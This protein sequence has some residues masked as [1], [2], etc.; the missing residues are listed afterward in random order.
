[1]NARGS[2]L[3]SCPSHRGCSTGQRSPLPHSEAKASS[4]MRSNSAISLAVTSCQGREPA[5]L[6]NL[7][8]ANPPVN[9][10]PH[11][12]VVAGNGRFHKASSSWCRSGRPAS[13]AAFCWR[14]SGA[15]LLSCSHP[16]TFTTDFEELY[17]P[18]VHPCIRP[19]HPTVGRRSCRA[20]LPNSLVRR[21]SNGSAVDGRRRRN[22]GRT[23]RKASATARGVVAGVSLSAS[24][25]DGVAGWKIAPCPP[26]GQEIAVGNI[27]SYSPE[28]AGRCRPVSNSDAC[29]VNAK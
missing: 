12:S 20:G 28:D 26:A 24:L 27:A 22:G 7:Q 15:R 5:H 23:P 16:A 10:A 3:R 18:T 21:S 2:P 4:M 13:L 17:C 6:E 8:V 19:A 14:A 1:M 29:F 9:H 25:V 11:Y